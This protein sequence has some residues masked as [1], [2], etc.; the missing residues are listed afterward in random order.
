MC[1]RILRTDGNTQINWNNL[2]SYIQ[3]AIKNLILKAIQ[4][5]KNLRFYIQKAIKKFHI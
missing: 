4:K 3:N 5:F 2:S 1:I